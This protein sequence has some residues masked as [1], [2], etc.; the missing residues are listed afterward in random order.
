[1]IKPFKRIDSDK[2]EAASQIRVI[3]AT[4]SVVIHLD[5]GAF[6]VFSFPDVLLCRFPK[7]G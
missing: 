7:V 6:L 3:P 5:S 1:M 4:D 2:V